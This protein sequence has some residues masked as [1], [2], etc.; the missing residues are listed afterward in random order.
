MSERARWVTA[1]H[2][3]RTRAG[4]NTDEEPAARNQSDLGFLNI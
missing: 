4:D 3:L 1:L 2:K